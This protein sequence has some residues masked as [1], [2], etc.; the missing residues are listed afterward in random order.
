MVFSFTSFFE[1]AFTTEVR[2]V[3]FGH[4]SF[5]AAL[6]SNGGDITVKDCIF[7]VSHLPKTLWTLLSVL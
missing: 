1:Q 5:A 7:K 4:S 2:G 3:T 6:L